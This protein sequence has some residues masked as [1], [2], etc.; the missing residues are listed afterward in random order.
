LIFRDFLTSGLVGWFG[1]FGWFGWLQQLFGKEV[2][3]LHVISAAFLS[4]QVFYRFPLVA[5]FFS[6]EVLEGFLYN[7]LC[8]R[9]R[10]QHTMHELDAAWSGMKH[11]A[12]I[13]DSA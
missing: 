10:V 7:V 1:W 5:G 4:G 9:R 6:F 12:A 11:S 3:Y 2:E 13:Q 8:V